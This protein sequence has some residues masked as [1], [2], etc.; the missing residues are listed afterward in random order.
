MSA[1]VVRGARSSTRSAVRSSQRTERCSGATSPSSTYR[2]N[3]SRT[4]SSLGLGVGTEPLARRPFSHRRC[5][6][7]PAPRPRGRGRPGRGTP[8]GDHRLTHRPSRPARSRGERPA[9]AVEGAPATGQGMERD[10]LPAPLRGGRS[11]GGRAGRDRLG[12][13]SAPLQLDLE[14]EPL[15]PSADDVDREVH[16]GPLARPGGVPRS[17]RDPS[18]R[19]ERAGDNTI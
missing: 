11:G 9:H 19:G 3:T 16:A 1:P 18:G 6:Q 14:P 8:T 15:P 2:E 10:R 13:W 12:R 4:P 7:R 17:F 5:R